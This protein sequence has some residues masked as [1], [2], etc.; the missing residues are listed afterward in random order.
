VTFADDDLKILQA[1]TGNLDCLA[2]D[3]LPQGKLHALIARLQASEAMNEYIAHEDY[4][5]RNRNEAGEPTADGGYRM[6]YAGKWY[7]SNPVDETP[8][9]DCGLAELWEEWRKAA[10]K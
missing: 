8:K 1:W 4:C 7:R 2:F 5:I 3:A 9:C 6:K 10:S